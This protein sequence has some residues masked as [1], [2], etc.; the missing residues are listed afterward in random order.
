MIRVLVI[1]DH[2][3]LRDALRI[4]LEKE[5]GVQLVGEAGD[6]LE[7]ISWRRARVRM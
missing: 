5:D 4:L 2:Q 7:G 1:D 6:A 3:L